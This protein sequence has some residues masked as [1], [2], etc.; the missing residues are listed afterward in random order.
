MG[1]RQLGSGKSWE[2]MWGSDLY[3]S[4]FTS[5]QSGTDFYTSK[6]AKSE[7]IH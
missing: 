4:L 6:T 5:F 2:A 7:G 3:Y 1:E